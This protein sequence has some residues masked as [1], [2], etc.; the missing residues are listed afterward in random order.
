VIATASPGKHDLLARRGATPVAYGDGLLN[1]VRA[2]A[3][4]GVTAAVDTVGTDEAVDVSLAL[5]PDRSRIVTIAAFARAPQEGIPLIGGGPGADP[6]EEIRAAARLQLTALVGAGR[7]EVVVARTFP[8]ADAA[9]AHRESRDG[10][11][12]GKLVLLP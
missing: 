5:V 12:T 4:D 7:L 2:L 11:A 1:R 6:G 8:L 9:A 3:P 10:H